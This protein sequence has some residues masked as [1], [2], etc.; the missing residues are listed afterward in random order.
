MITPTWYIVLYQRTRKCMATICAVRSRNA[1]AD[2]S[3]MS[4]RDITHCDGGWT[5]PGAKGRM[6][7]RRSAKIALRVLGGATLEPHML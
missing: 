1:P 3:T 2:D 7:E 5:R 4:E 6:A